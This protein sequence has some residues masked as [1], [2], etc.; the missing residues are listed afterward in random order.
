MT[1]T[2]TNAQ[3][4]SGPCKA[5]L[6]RC[7]FGPQFTSMEEARQYNDLKRK[8]LRT[9]LTETID[10][11][12]TTGGI[13]GAGRFVDVPTGL[14]GRMRILPTPGIG[15]RSPTVYVGISRQPSSGRTQ[16]GG[17]CSSPMT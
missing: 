10:H 4:V 14:W 3:G 16:P 11:T 6:G 7:P 2:H 9:D 8:G 15:T 13:S 12:P 1:L 5:K 17:P